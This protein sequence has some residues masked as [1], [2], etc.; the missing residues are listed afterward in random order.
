MIGAP[1]ANLVSLFRRT[2]G[3]WTLVQVITAPDIASIYSQFGNSAAISSDTTT[4]VVGGPGD[5][6][7]GSGDR[8]HVGVLRS[9]GNR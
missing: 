7:I 9:A 5:N 1:G 3:A 4:L 8:R 6:P 2:N